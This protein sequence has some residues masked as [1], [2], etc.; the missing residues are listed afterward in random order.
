MNAFIVL[1][2]ETFGCNLAVSY[3]NG[4]TL[5]CRDIDFFNSNVWYA[6]FDI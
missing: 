2:D 5:G 3:I 4:P 6:Q 1:D